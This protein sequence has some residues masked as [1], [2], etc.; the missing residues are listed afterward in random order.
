MSDMQHFTWKEGDALNPSFRYPNVLDAQ[1]G[2]IGDYR[3]PHVVAYGG[4]L[5]S[6]AMIAG[7]VEI[8]YPI[9]LVLFADTGGERPETY[10][11]I[12][13]F[14]DWLESVGYPPVQ[15]VQKVSREGDPMTLEQQ[16]L[17]KEM[18]PALAYGYKKC[19]LKFKR[20][21]QDKFCNNWAPACD[22][23][24][25]GEL[26]VKMIGYDITEPQRVGNAPEED[27]KYLYKYPLF[28]WQWTRDKCKEKLSEVGLCP[29]EKS[30]CFFCPAMK[31]REIR[32][33]KAVHPE[34]A[35]RAREMERGA[36]KNL[37]KIKGLGRRFS[38]DEYLQA[39]ED[40]Q[41]LF[42]ETPVMEE[43]LCYD[44]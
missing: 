11:Y 36:K 19:S 29:P 10:N 9:D 2:Y 24:D 31:K 13:M 23:W 5:N 6:S 27:D 28:D 40:Q 30:S 39:E 33:L 34:L 17:D 43:C 21:P 3:T 44:G 25:R 16:C 32:K 22:A 14:S 15:T 20:G 18:L 38:W 42:P 26:V 4:G 41:R 12:E 7:C 35:E 37:K 1:S 8:G